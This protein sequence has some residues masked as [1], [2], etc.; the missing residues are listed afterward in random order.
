M[1]RLGEAACVAC[2]SLRY[3]WK[4]RRRVSVG[5]QVYRHATS[6]YTFHQKREENRFCVGNCTEKRRLAILV[7]EKSLGDTS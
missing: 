1:E 3:T 5:T 4:P 2:F 7:P 6:R